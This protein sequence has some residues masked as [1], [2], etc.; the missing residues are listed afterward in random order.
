MRLRIEQL[1]NELFVMNERLVN[2]EFNQRE[3]K[4][5]A[6]KNKKTKKIVAYKVIYVN[7]SDLQFLT[8]ISA[9]LQEGWT[10]ANGFC[11]SDRAKVQPLI[12][13]E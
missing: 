4:F 12:K 6:G 10:I 9:C 5:S 13:Y 11:E 2:L 7:G 8:N 3:N 1:E